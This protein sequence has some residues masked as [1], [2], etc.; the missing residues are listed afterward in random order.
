[1]II[2]AAAATVQGPDRAAS[3]MLLT[4]RIARSA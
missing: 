2:V 3:V 4:R 1:M